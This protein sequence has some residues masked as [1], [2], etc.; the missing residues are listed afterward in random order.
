MKSLLV[1][2]LSL[3]SIFFSAC[4]TKSV[5]EPEEV[6]SQWKYFETMEQTIV[7][8]T[9]DVAMFEDRKILSKNI[10]IDGVVDSKYRL[11]S[12]SDGWIITASIDGKLKLRQIS[13]SNIIEE[14]ELNKTVAAASVDDD[15][16]A[17]LF[18]DNE[19]AMFSIKTKELLFKDQGGSALAVDTR[20]VSPRFLNG[21]VVFATLDGKIIIVNKSTKKKLRSSIISSEKNFNNVIYFDVI[22]KK[23]VAATAYQILSMSQKE[24]RQKY[25]I[26]NVTYDNVNIFLTTKQGELVSLTPNLELNAKLKFPF[27]HFLGLIVHENKVYALEKEGYLVVA[28]TDLSSFEVYE[29]DVDE[30]FVFVGEDKFYINDTLISVKQ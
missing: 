28:P 17:I 29:T 3:S 16:L 23:I 6:K 27:A 5:F 25:E 4:S 9:S 12:R 30:G 13:A 11:I 22:N 15:T 26:R 8:V 14:F 10:A 18:A 19:I 1:L 7:D 24:V 21:V 2:L 20:I